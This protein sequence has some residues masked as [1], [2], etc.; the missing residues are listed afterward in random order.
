MTEPAHNMYCGVLA[1]SEEE[2]RQILIA[3]GH[4]ATDDVHEM[5]HK[6]PPTDEE[7]LPIY[8]FAVWADGGALELLDEVELLSVYFTLANVHDLPYELIN[9]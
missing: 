7:E 1:A 9:G 6:E 8:I 2:G 4:F 5:I 3:E